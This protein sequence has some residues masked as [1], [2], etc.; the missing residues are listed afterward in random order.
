MFLCVHRMNIYIKF[1]SKSQT[2]KL[3]LKSLTYES[4]IKSMTSKSTSSP[5]SSLRIPNHVS[6]VHQSP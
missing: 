3:S 1:V 4:I 5:E 6:R 2:V